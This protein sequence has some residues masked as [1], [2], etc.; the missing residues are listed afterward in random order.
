MVATSKSTIVV[1]PIVVVA[2]VATI[3]VVVVVVVVAVVVVEIAIIVT[4]AV[5][6]DVEVLET[7]VAIATEIL[8]CGA[9][10]WKLNQ[11]RQTCFTR[12]EGQ[13]AEHVWLTQ[14]T[15][16]CARIAITD[17]ERKCTTNARSTL[18]RSDDE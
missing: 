15:E 6:V 8:A 3:V 12:S 18:Q 4:A 10:T 13:L 7:M 14:H 1:G 5:V 16:A 2:A 17:S 11:L 9:A